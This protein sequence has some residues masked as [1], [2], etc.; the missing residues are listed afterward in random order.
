MA[1]KSHEIYHRRLSISQRIL[2]AHAMFACCV[3]FLKHIYIFGQ[4]MMLIIYILLPVRFKWYFARFLRCRVCLIWRTRMC[5][6]WRG[7]CRDVSFNVN[8][9]H[10]WPSSICLGGRVQ[11]YFGWWAGMSAQASWLMQVISYS[12]HILI[13]VQWRNTNTAQV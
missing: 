3:A 7:M 9:L 5:V 2:L 4:R 12:S 13:A 1:F 11:R 8:K 10:L 6:W